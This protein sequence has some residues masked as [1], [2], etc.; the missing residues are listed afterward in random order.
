MDSAD[1]KKK[2]SIHAER[3]YALIFSGV[4]TCETAADQRLFIDALICQCVTFT[5]ILSGEQEFL[6]LID[7]LKNEVIDTMGA[8]T[9]RRLH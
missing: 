4:I 8:E 5:R 9:P 7:R 2:V 3:A 1:H 6:A